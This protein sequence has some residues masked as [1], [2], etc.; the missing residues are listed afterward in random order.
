VAADRELVQRY[1]QEMAE[2]LAAEVALW[3]AKSRAQAKRDLEAHGGRYSFERSHCGAVYNLV[4]DYLGDSE[5]ML[6]ILID[7]QP[8]NSERIDAIAVPRARKSGGWTEEEMG[9]MS[10]IIFLRR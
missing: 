8:D 1:K 5:D 3:E 4:V 7:I 10:E 2:C 9:M 6:T